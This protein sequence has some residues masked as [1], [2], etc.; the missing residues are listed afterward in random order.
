[1]RRQEQVGNI[2]VEAEQ[3]PQ[4]GR[5]VWGVYMLPEANEYGEVG[6]QVKYLGRYATKADAMSEAKKRSRK[7]Q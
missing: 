4:G 3:N 7:E 5:S 1:M 6:G 2:L